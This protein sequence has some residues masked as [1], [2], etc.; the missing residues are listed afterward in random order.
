MQA[1]WLIPVR[2][3]ARWLGEAVESALADSAP[4]D[5]MVIV[6]D[7]STDGPSVPSDPRIRFVRQ[8]PL[9]IVAALE[10]GR[11]LVRTPL[12]ARLDADDRVIPGRLAAQRAAMVA[13]PRLAAV[14]GRARAHRDDA[15]VPEGMRRYV[16]WVN[17]LDDPHREILVESPMFH[18]ASTF[19]AD[20]V[21]QIGGYRSGDFPEDYDLFLR[22]AAAGW[23]LA[24]LPREVLA[25]RDREGRL[26]RT[27]PRYDRRAFLPL[28]LDFLGRTSLRAPRRVVLWGGGRAGRPWTPYLMERGHQVVAVLDLSDA[29]S[30]HGVPVLRPEA[31]TQLRFDVLL[32]AV[33]ARGAR[34]EI[35][36]RIAAMRPELVEGR[37]WFAVA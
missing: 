33:G 28:K 11:A 6:D 8:P 24:N 25:W 14:G 19:R 29:R 23:K 3:C 2:D 16:S 35:R 10:R 1:T 21:A 31:L 4:G 7:G 17:G 27:D 22:L 5:E 12:I 37:D 13:D 34:E 9:G 32:V 26:T 18:P 20:A 30:R 15:P 36:G